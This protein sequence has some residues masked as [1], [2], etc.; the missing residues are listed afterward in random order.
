VSELL[1]YYFWLI[2]PFWQQLDILVYKR[3]DPPSTFLWPKENETWDPSRLTRVISREAHLFLDTALG[4]LTSA[5]R[6]CNI[7]PTSVVRRF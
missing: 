1:V 7:P 4:I 6:N 3:K 5:S 2:L